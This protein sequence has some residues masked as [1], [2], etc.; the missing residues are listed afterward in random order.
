M[1][2]RYQGFLFLIYVWLINYDSPDS[3]HRSWDKLLGNLILANSFS[4]IE[5]SVSIPEAVRIPELPRS[6]SAWGQSDVGGS[7]TAPCGTEVPR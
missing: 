2:R 3:Q 5:Q 6:E 1:R 4:Q 7:G